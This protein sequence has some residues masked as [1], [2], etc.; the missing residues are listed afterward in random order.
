[1]ATYNVHRWVGGDGHQD[2]DRTLRV[3]AG[4]NAD[5]IA[6]QEVCPPDQGPS[7][8]AAQSLARRT[9]LQVIAGPTLQEDR[10]DYGNLVLT[11]L[12]VEKI[13]R[14]DIS[15]PSREP[16]GAVMATVTAKGKKVRL[17]ATH[18][19]LRAW[20]R[21]RQLNQILE[22]FGR[23]NQE[24]EILLGDLNEWR[25]WSPLLRRLGRTFTPSL[26]LPTFPARLPVLALD[27]IW[28]RP[29]SWKAKFNLGG[30]SNLTR[31]ASDHLPLVADF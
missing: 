31:L 22:S 25:P 11:R 19:G 9:G 17:V 26:Y 13:C 29:S 1:M 8:S 20:E 6:L 15:V 27:R 18:L 16:R 2:I 21:R 12:P 5:V 30:R 14:L 7:F 4:L 3:I 23:Q 28:Y 10:G 24:L